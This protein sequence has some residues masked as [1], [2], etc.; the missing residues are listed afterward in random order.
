MRYAQGLYAPVKA[1]KCSK[2]TMVKFGF[3]AIWLHPAVKIWLDAILAP[4]R[5]KV[6]NTKLVDAL[7]LHPGY[8]HGE[9]LVGR[10]L[11]SNPVKGS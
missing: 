11:G 5:L 2:Y 1:Q 7:W 3:D 6:H 4:I 9:I 8:V 10:D